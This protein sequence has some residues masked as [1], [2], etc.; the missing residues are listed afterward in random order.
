[1]ETYPV[2]K[3]RLIRLLC[4]IAL[5]LAA[6]GAQAGMV[7]TNLH[8][9][10]DFHDGINPVAPLV[11]GSDGNFYGTTYFGGT[12]GGNG[13]VFEIS[14]NGALT[15][16]Y[17][18]TGGDDG[19]NPPAG[20]LPVGDGIFYGVTEAGGSNSYGTLFQISTNGALTSLHSFTGGNDGAFP[21]AGLVQGTNGNFYGTA[22]SGG[23]HDNGTV[24]QIDTNG[25]VSGLYS[26]TGGNDGANPQAGLVQG[27]DGHFY[28]TTAGGGTNGAGTV[29]KVSTNGTLTSLYSFTGA[30]DGA[31]PEAGLWPG[32][33][34]SFY[35]TTVNGGTNGFGTV[36]QIS[37]NGVLTS[38]HSF[39]GA[40]DGANPED[41]L[42]LGSDG[43][44]Y[45]TTLA[46]GSNNSG[47][48]FQ[49][50]TNGALISLHSFIGANDGA[51]PH[52]GLAQGADGYFYG[53][54]YEGGTN[55]FGTVFQISTNGVLLSLFSFL[56]ANDGANPEAG[57]V[58]A[59]DGNFY[60]TTYSG[61]AQGDGTVFRVLTNGVLTSL[62]SF[63]GLADG[64]SPDAALVQGAD[65]NLY[66]TTT[67]GGT[68]NAGSVFEFSTN[69]ALASLYSFTGGNDGGK[70]ECALVQSSDGILYGT[71]ESGGT[72]VYFGTVF[73]ITT[74]GAL[75]NLYSFNGGNLGA[76]P[77]SGLVQGSDGNFYGTT[78]WGGSNFYGTVFQI[79]SNG[80]LAVLYG[81]SG[82]N[83]GGNPQGAL[84]QGLD[85]NF[86]GTTVNGGKHNSGAVFKI[87]TKGV[88]TVLYSFTGLK[89]GAN[90]EA[91]V[92]LGDDGN[93][94]GTTYWGGTNGY[95]GVFQIS[96]K[97]A[98]TNLYSFTGGP[99][100][101]N[102]QGGLVLG[103]DGNFYG[104]TQNGGYGGAGTI[105]LITG[106][107]VPPAFKAVTLTDTTLSLTWR[108]Y[109][110]VAYQLQYN[111]DLTSTNWINLG[112]VITATVGTFITNDFITNGAQRF[113]RVALVP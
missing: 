22:Y 25:V 28:G 46:G 75:S 49:I 51:L 44:F 113:Y 59:S 4:T 58:Q 50:G 12:H 85:G 15:S 112:G 95:G 105:F 94:Y 40:G 14:T 5:L 80:T 34:G 78:Y 54:T 29:F 39:N 87:T 63:S 73:E 37:S 86:Y 82:G 16:L 23:K 81:F 103:F 30:N 104:T 10:L 88:L 43:N 2:L 17:S 18:F 97:G 8:S 71:T 47:T 102:P 108:T 67:E 69:G 106:N 90:P 110:G 99:D 96:P 60:G 107:R 48:V 31:N 64:A 1:M 76:Y 32:S 19:A 20:L 33:D 38:L 84:V 27:G 101:A 109:P 3:A 79:S 21:R 26:F 68:S 35:G 92:A 24:F 57:L 89:D 93:F 45:G 13:T 11:Q 61:G 56:G 72:N 66:G 91:G 70:P 6:L 55:D 65:G 36:F 111:T 7:F 98:M 83:D 100:G 53:T 42:A 74:D 41:G 9:F 62:Y 77:Y 52:A